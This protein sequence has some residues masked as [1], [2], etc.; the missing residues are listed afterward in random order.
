[1][2]CDGGTG[3]HIAVAVVAVDAWIASDPSNTHL[4]A[5]RYCHS[6]AVAIDTDVAAV[7]EDGLCYFQRSGST[8]VVDTFDGVVAAVVE[9]EAAAAVAGS[10]GSRSR[11]NSRDGT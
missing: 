10:P 8:F 4:I 7:V 11:S 3:C 2:L 9:A 5:Y 1:M 6:F